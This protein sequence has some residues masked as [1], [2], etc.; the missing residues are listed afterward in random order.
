LAEDKLKQYCGGSTSVSHDVS[1]LRSD[2][3]RFQHVHSS[4]SP[5]I[6]TSM[7][8]QITVSASTM[9]AAEFASLPVLSTVRRSP[10]QTMDAFHLS[11]FRYTQYIQHCWFPQQ[12]RVQALQSH[13]GGR[14]VNAFR[15][16]GCLGGV[17][18]LAYISSIRRRDCNAA[19]AGEKEGGL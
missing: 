5:E 14:I 17:K 2:L 16:M 13:C 9:Y 7:Y 18:L 4:R 6:N 3:A 10:D 1:G 19:I 12:S 15:K 8:L 11:R